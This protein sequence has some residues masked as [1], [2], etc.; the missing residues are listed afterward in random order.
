MRFPKHFSGDEYE[1]EKALIY[2]EMQE[3]KSELFNKFS[4]YSKE[5]GFQVNTSNAGIYFSPI[6]D[7][8]PMGE[9]EYNQLDEEEKEKHK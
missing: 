7:G 9:E 3:K 4:E 8:Q 2:K 1:N 5:Q 6:V